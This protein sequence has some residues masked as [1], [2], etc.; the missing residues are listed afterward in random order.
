MEKLI[1][2]ITFFFTV[3]VYSQK[4]NMAPSIPVSDEYFGTKIV[5]E[6]RNLEN[7]K[8]PEVTNWMESQSDFT[9][10]I[11]NSIPNKNYYVNKRLEFDKKQGYSISDIKITLNGKY[12]YLKRNA[13]ERTAKVYYRNTFN[14][15]EDLLYDP[16][17]FVSN[18]YKTGHEYLINLISPSWDGA[19]L[20][21]SLTEKGKEFSKVIVIDVKTKYIYPEIITNSNPSNIGG[22]KWLD[23]NSGFFYVY[24]PIVDLSSDQFKKNTQSILYRIGEDP[25]KLNDVFSSTNNPNLR[26]SS[27]EYPA[28]LTFNPDDQYYIGILVDAEDFRKT[29]I[30]D[31]KDLL[32]GKKDWKLLYDKDS[33]VFSIRLSG[34]DIYFLSGYNSSNYK[35]CK[36]SIT[37]KNFKAPEVLIPEKQDEVIKQYVLTKDGIYYVTTK[38]GVEAKLYVYQNGKE[39]PI[40]LPYVSGRIDLQSKGKAYSDIWITCSGWANDEQR[41][42]YDLSTNTFNQ[43]NLTPVIDYPEFKDII[44]EELSVKSYDGTEVPL[45]LIYNKKLKK[46]TT[47]PVLIDCY[48]AF[49]QSQFPFFAK[50]YLLWANQG[51][52]MAIAHVRGG[53]EK[54]VRWHTDGQ[55][56]KKSNTW[57]DLIACAEYLIEKKYASSEKIAIWG[58]SAGGIAIGRAMT[59][60]PELFKVAIIESGVLNTT[61]FDNNGIQKTSMKEYGNPNDPM[62]FKGLLEMDSYLHIKKGEKYPSTLIYTGINDPKIS[63]WQSTKFVAKL[64]ADNSSKNPILLNIDYEGGHGGDI[65]VTQRYSNLSNIFAFAFWQL[66][67]P[68]YQPKENIKK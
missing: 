60:R 4:N 58:A 67:H 34:N 16:T 53:G 21:I 64:Q 44:V 24:Y 26:I 59:E 52:V 7:L 36:T 37:T 3:S 65:P 41:F 49:G 8:D 55:K 30:I 46:N 12:F 61:R 47:N 22:I 17:D 43:E 54:G 15:K 19:K 5:D 13:K 10:S 40:K 11:L 48:G 29:F 9:A 14:G 68:D 56:S 35:L 45:S 6:F 23:D 28:I 66:G 27:E 38:N 18:I 51:G 39:T 63:P 2:S 31:K 20:A 42:R 32:S 25:K 57:K 33:K 62:E 50:S 1:F